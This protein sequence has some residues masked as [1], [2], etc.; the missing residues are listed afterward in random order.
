MTKHDSPD[1]ARNPTNSRTATVLRAM[2]ALP[3]DRT[4]A[5]SLARITLPLLAALATA[6][7]FK[8]VYAL[9]PVTQTT[10]GWVQPSGSKTVLLILTSPPMMVTSA[11][12]LFF[13]YQRVRR[14]GWQALSVVLTSVCIVLLALGLVRVVRQLFVHGMPLEGLMLSGQLAR[15]DLLFTVGFGLLSLLVL[16][17][18]RATWRRTTERVLV[19]LAFMLSVICAMELVHYEKTGVNG[20]GPLM[21]YAIGQFTDLHPLLISE[22][23]RRAA[24]ALTIPLTA[25]AV[26]YSAITLIYPLT[27]SSR[28]NLQSS[29]RV[30]IGI[31]VWPIIAVLLL[32]PPVTDQQY[33]RLSANAPLTLTK[34]ILA[35]LLIEPSAHRQLANVDADIPR[36]AFRATSSTRPLNVIVVILESV[37]A[38]ATSVYNADLATTPFLA[39]LS[40][41]SIVVDSMYAVVP[42]TSAAWVSILQGIPPSTNSALM[43]WAKVEADNSNAP[44]IP[45]LLRPLGYK[46]AF[47]VPTHMRYE[48][49]GQLIRNMGFDQIISAENFPSVESVNYF[50]FEDRTLLRPILDWV[51]LQRQNNTPFFLAVMTN[52][53]HHKYDVPASFSKRNFTNSSDH[54][55]NNYLNCI[56]YIDTYIQDL[57][58]GLSERDILESS[59]VMIV[60]DHGESFGEHG[61]RQHAMSMYEESLH[62]PMIIYAPILVAQGTR[63][64]GVRHQLDILPTIADAL[65][66]EI[67]GIFPFGTSLLSPVPQDRSIYFSSIL[68]DVGIGMRRGDMKYIYNFG[69]TPLQMYDL[70]VDPGE[71]MDIGYTLHD[72]QAKVVEE[73]M[74]GWY[75]RGKKRFIQS[76]F[77]HRRPSPGLQ[78]GSP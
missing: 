64:A 78:K 1:G 75:E 51:D 41:R 9:W 30:E 72:A 36:M 73:E 68:E 54:D 6:K 61:I 24:L 12:L 35:R 31:I 21:L 32:L 23:D 76:V 22:F 17:G 70:S 29:Q 59:I 55:L 60:G 16:A 74:V 20:S 38:S 46:S 77:A 8:S 48:G 18:S 40:R 4:L 44:S 62:V 37:R 15:L 71:K 67:D 10:L 39:E 56:A 50:G 26:T 69:R 57:F 47:F 28:A 43:T 66:V 5:I 25:W 2:L 3:I 11:L 53:G 49:E 52:V 33:A 65:R 63:S 14:H 13:L 19:L 58:V 42:R 34:D 7:V 27:K 45:R